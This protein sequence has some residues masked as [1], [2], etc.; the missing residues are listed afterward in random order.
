MKLSPKALVLAGFAAFMPV[1]A[2]SQPLTDAELDRAAAP[3][4]TAYNDATMKECVQHM[5]DDKY[6]QLARNVVA[7][8]CG[9]LASQAA[10]ALKQGDRKA[11]IDFRLKASDCAYG[12]ITVTE[13][14]T[15]Q[16]EAQVWGIQQR[17][18][19]MQ[20]LGDAR[21]FTVKLP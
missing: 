21:R 8:R 6:A 16:D 17:A 7:N 14:K 5:P 19:T 18:A 13:D 1:S 4:C 2:A 9:Q 20:L 12:L 10:R 3:L 11:A 15:L